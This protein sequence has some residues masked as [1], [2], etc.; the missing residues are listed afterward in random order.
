MVACCLTMASRSTLLKS[1]TIKLGVAQWISVNYNLKSLTVAG[2]AFSSPSV[3]S[4]GFLA[5]F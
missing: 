5:F 2:T 1:D 4:L 3:K